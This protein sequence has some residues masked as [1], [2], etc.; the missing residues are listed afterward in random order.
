[1]SLEVSALRALAHPLRLQILSLLTGT[2]LSAAEVA[3]E[4]GTTQANASYH[5]RVLAEAGEVVTA[6][7]EKIRG[8]VAKRYRHPWSPAAQTA[9]TPQR[10]GATGPA[11]QSAFMRALT[12]E[13]LRR[14]GLRHASPEG[15]VSDAE[16]WVTPA[17]WS[18]VSALVRQASELIHSSASPPRTPGTI[19][20]NLVAVL[21]RMTDDPTS[22]EPAADG[23]S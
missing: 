1:M 4:L 18:E 2:A 17:A 14:N 8:G 7:E 21:F 9:Q 10:T 20:V 11:E 23:T 15:Y 13:L 22:S 12:A 6:G 16:M 3:R 5:L 19:H